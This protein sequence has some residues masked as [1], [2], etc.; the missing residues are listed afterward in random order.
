MQSPHA[1]QYAALQ[2]LLADAELPARTIVRRSEW[3]KLVGLH[4][5]VVSGAIDRRELREVTCG[6]ATGVAV[7]DFIAWAEKRQLAITVGQL[8]KRITHPRP[9]FVP[10]KGQVTTAS[11]TS[12]LSE[13]ARPAGG[14]Y[15]GPRGRRRI[16]FRRM[17]LRSADTARRL[18]PG[19]EFPAD[20]LKY[21]D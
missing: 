17:R 8:P 2:R 15:G 6:G 3:P 12:M 21:L 20:I 11:A 7:A 14:I 9:P 13:Y 4:Y 1:N 18:S 19:R 10:D 5:E 16:G